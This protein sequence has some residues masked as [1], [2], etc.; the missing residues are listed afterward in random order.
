VKICG[1][2]NKV[3]SVETSDVMSQSVQRK[4]A[5]KSNILLALLGAF[6]RVRGGRASHVPQA[7]LVGGEGCV[8]PHVDQDTMNG[9]SN[10]VGA[11]K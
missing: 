7:A 9:V 8:V 2:V 4:K 6:L 5:C 1:S 11:N 10:L 3:H